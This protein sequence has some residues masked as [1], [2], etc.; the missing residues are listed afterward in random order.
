MKRRTFLK[1]GSAVTFGLAALQTSTSKARILGANDRVRLGV[2]G[3]ANR[4][5]QDL[6]AFAK[7]DDV[8]IAALCDVDKNSLEKAAQVYERFKPFTTGDFRKVYDRN[9]IDGVVIATPDH[10][11]AIQT[12]DACKA[13][14]DV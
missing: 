5:M 3:T 1:T 14:K 13:G 12:V 9:D 11:H 6:D 2:L 8:E 4:G 10:W 7:H